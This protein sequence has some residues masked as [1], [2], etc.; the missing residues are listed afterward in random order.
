ME[1]EELISATKKVL[2]LA[3]SE[4][5][6]VCVRISVSGAVRHSVLL[7]N[8]TDCELSSAITEFLDSNRPEELTESNPV[9]MIIYFS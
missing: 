3:P 1:Q 2:E 9:E 6:Y 5:A 7:T 8:S 4:F